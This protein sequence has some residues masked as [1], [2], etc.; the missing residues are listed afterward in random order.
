MSTLSS[1]PAL[2]ATPGIDLA[3]SQ[4][5]RWWVIAPSRSSSRDVMKVLDYVIMRIWSWRRSGVPAAEQV[6][7]RGTRLEGRRRHR[8]LTSFGHGA[9][10]L[11]S[12]LFGRRL[13]QVSVHL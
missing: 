7:R 13:R 6:L 3:S 2:A 1:F 10:S 4:S 8:R 5:W 12:D 11:K 9:I